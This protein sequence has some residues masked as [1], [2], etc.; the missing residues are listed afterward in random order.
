MVSPIIWSGKQFFRVVGTELHEDTLRIRSNYKNREYV[1]RLVLPTLCITYAEMGFQNAIGGTQLRWPDSEVYGPAYFDPPVEIN[2]AAEI[3]RLT[4]IRGA[5]RVIIGPKETMIEWY[6]FRDLVVPR[7][8]ISQD[9]PIE[10]LIEVENAVVEVRPELQINI[11]QYANGRLIGGVT[12]EKR[13][14]EWV[15]PDP[16]QRGYRLWVRVV[17][18]EKREPLVEAK[19]A[20]FHWVAAS[21]TDPSVGEFVLQEEHPTDSSGSVVIEPRTPGILEAVT[22]AMEGWRATARVWRALEG[23]P[24]NLLMVASRLKR[25]QYPVR[26]RR[27]ERKIYAAAY[28]LDPGDTLELL[29]ETF[30]YKSVEEL[31][32]M[33]GGTGIDPGAP[34]PLPGWYFLHAQPGDTLEK[35]ASDFE[36]DPRWPRTVGRHH[37]PNNSVVIEHEIVAIPDPTFAASREP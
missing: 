24:V 4:W 6:G 5:H 28:T 34:I 12:V 16:E 3:E 35:I 32:E 20:F 25:A 23:Q 37:R 22:L 15:P 33:I 8:R 21:P 31:A 27:L 36:L 10:A 11:G 2:G 14:P 19:L 7:L 30:R 9:Q 18:F 17:D 1:S 26:V 13:H 29:A